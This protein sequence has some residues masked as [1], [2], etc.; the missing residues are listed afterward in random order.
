MTKMPGIYEQL[1]DDAYW[2]DAPQAEYP[3]VS[4]LAR[5]VDVTDILFPGGQAHVRDQFSQLRDNERRVML[6][7]GEPLP[8]TGPKTSLLRI[9]MDER[10]RRE[11]EFLDLRDDR[12]PMMYMDATGFN[13]YARRMQRERWYTGPDASYAEFADGIT[14]RMQRTVAYAVRSRSGRQLLA[15]NSVNIPKDPNEGLVR[16]RY[17]NDLLPPM[18]VGT[19]YATEDW[20]GR[21]ERRIVQAELVTPFAGQQRLT[22]GRKVS[23]WLS[24]SGIVRGPEVSSVKL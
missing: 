12:D 10:H 23:S 14:T 9:V 7:Y 17:G 2:I 24:L 19:V 22:G 18:A 6:D 15:V 8:L 20:R 1:A 4:I 3:D 16:Q 5:A 11:G 13:K 21:T